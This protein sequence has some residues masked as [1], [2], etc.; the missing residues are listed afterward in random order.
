MLQMQAEL[1]AFGIENEAELKDY[2]LTMHN[3][4]EVRQELQQ[5]V[6]HYKHAVP[7]LQPGRIVKLKSH[8]A[9]RSYLSRTCI[10]SCT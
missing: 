5:L 4:A 2:L 7:F 9:S 8:I 10:L 6:N 3:A 1:D